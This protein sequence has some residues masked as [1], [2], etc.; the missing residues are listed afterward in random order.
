MNGRPGASAPAF[1]GKAFVVLQ[2]ERGDSEE[3]PLVDSEGAAPKLEPGASTQLTVRPYN[4]GK[5]K[6]VKVRGQRRF[7]THCVRERRLAGG[8]RAIQ[9]EEGWSVLLSSR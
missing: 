5:L 2:C 4:L 1:S 3:L 7:M 6:G 9:G 8:L